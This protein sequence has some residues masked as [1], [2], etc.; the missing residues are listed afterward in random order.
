M[1]NALIAEK[2]NASSSRSGDKP[3]EETKKTAK[4]LSARTGVSSQVP[5][6]ARSTLSAPKGGVIKTVVLPHEDFNRL[7]VEG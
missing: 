5:S 3:N 7:G 2:L 1:T 6:S 4:V